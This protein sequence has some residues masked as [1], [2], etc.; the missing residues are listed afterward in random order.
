MADKS[1][2][3]NVLCVGVWIRKWFR[4]SWCLGRKTWKHYPTSDT[5]TSWWS[6]VTAISLPFYLHELWFI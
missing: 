3:T 5:S 2:K 4:L 6:K 1:V